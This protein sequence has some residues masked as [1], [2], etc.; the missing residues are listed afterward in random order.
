[1][2]RKEK[3]KLESKEVGIDVDDNII[4]E[5]ELSEAKKTLE[6]LSIGKS[7]IKSDFLPTIILPKVI[8]KKRFNTLTITFFAVLTF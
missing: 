7:S 2:F 3:L 6:S 8:K 4:S 5:H 1:M